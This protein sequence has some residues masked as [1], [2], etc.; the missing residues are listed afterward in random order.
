EY[1]VEEARQGV[2]GRGRDRLAPRLEA[3]G[4]RADDAAAA[5]GPGDREGDLRLVEAGHDAVGDLHRAARSPGLAQGAADHGPVADEVARS[6]IHVN[7]VDARLARDVEVIG[8]PE[9]RL[10]L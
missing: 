5:P 8:A 10:E 2:Q 3:A 7:G 4:Q 9:L 6:P 1:P